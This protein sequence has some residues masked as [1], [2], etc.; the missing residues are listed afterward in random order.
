MRN[1]LA[2]TLSE[3][4]KEILK[5][6]D[7]DNMVYSQIAVTLGISRS[8]VAERYK[9]AKYIN[10]IIDK[11]KDVDPNTIGD[12]EFK[13]YIYS[14]VSTITYNA[15]SRGG[16]ILSKEKFMSLDDNKILELR[17]VGTKGYLEIKN[18]MSIINHEESK[19]EFNFDPHIID[20]EMLDIAKNFSRAGFEVLECYH[21]FSMYSYFQ[22]DRTKP[23]ITIKWDNADSMLLLLLR[24][25]DKYPMLEIKST[26]NINYKPCI[27]EE[28]KDPDTYFNKITKILNESTGK[29]L[30]IS[31]NPVAYAMV[32]GVSYDNEYYNKVILRIQDAFVKDLK[33]I[34]DELYKAALHK[35]TNKKYH[36]TY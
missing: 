4:D 17:N 30:I 18:V 33:Q 20:P 5:L 10:N 14:H 11:Y 28:I 24:L 2:R 34:S 3:V 35:E 1:E 6:R 8:R 19:E 21:G 31:T 23:H 26:H 9:R 16:Y 36:D 29:I 12:D 22:L 7:E 13:Y 32:R 25:V 15:L 27:E